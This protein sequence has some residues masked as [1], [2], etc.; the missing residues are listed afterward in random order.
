ML[1]ACTSFDNLFRGQDGV[2]YQNSYQGEGNLVTGGIYSLLTPTREEEIQQILRE[3]DSYLCSSSP[4]TLPV[5]TSSHLPQ[6]KLQEMTIG[7]KNCPFPETG[8]TMG[9]CTVAESASIIPAL[10]LTHQWPQVT[11]LAT[12]PSSVYSTSNDDATYGCNF[13]THAQTVQPVSD[14]KELELHHAFLCDFSGCE[15]RYTKS[16]YLGTHKRIHMGEKPFLCPWENCGW[17]FRRSDELKRHYRRH[18]GE[19][20]YVCPLCGRS[21]SRSDHRSSHI[22]KIHSL[23]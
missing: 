5:E 22:K 3:M 17:C 4:A 14:N 10:N 23:M 6:P 16:S 13:S 9:T 19:K 12:T 20:P 2:M 8:M 15:K 21:F 1:M 11:M 18:T 7:K